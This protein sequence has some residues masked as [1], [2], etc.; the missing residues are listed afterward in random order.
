VLRICALILCLLAAA[1]LNW[2]GNSSS[3]SASSVQSFSVITIH[4]DR[5]QSL[6]LPHELAKAL[7]P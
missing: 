2:K 6:V 5:S 4:I 7:L 3:Q 1:T